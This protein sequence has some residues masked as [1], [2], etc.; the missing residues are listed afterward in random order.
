M[1]KAPSPDAFELADA[2]DNALFMFAS[3]QISHAELVDDLVELITP[4]L[5]RGK[6]PNE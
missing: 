3:E 4:V 6:A 2:V 1:S 5:L